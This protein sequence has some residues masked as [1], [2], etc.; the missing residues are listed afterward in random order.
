MSTLG[1]PVRLAHR[2][3]SRRW[4][5][6]GVTSYSLP[7]GTCA[8]I[9]TDTGQPVSGAAISA[10]IRIASEPI[11]AVVRRRA[12]AALVPVIPAMCR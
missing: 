11:S 2:R 3:T 10:P 4:P 5:Q 8:K 9:T 7:T 6:R 1:V 12:V